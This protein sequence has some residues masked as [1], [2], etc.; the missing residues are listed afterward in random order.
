[1]KSLE[2]LTYSSQ[3]ASWIAEDVY[4]DW[5]MDAVVCYGDLAGKVTA[6]EYNMTAGCGDR[7][8]VRYINARSH[9]CATA[10]PCECLSATSSTF[11]TYPVP[12]FAWG[13]YD[14]LCN[15]TEWETCGPLRAK[16]MNEMAKRLAK[17]RDDKIW[18]ELTTN[19]SPNTDI[20]TDDTCSTAAMGSSCCTYSFN[21]YNCIIEAR[22]HLLSDGYDPDYVIMDPTVAAYLYYAQNHYPAEMNLKWTNDGHIKYIGELQVIETCTAT[23]CNNTSGSVQ[24][25]VIDSSR[26]VGEAWGKR[27][28]FNEFYDGKCDRT[29]I[30]IWQYWGASDLDCNA[31]VWISNP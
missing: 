5:I 10:D 15:F 13:D 28:T 31:I 25:V 29:E 18:S 8:Q 11:G 23:T 27:P 6:M 7:I 30:T 2:E 14:Q 9:S 1:M 26:A 19:I 17:C 22:Q 3:T 16:I 24:A 21:L 20:E 12:V 4:S